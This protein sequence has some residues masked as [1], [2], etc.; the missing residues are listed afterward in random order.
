MSISE[1]ISII[2]GVL[3]IFIGLSF[4]IKVFRKDKQEEL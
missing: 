2:V 4:I 3:F 1:I